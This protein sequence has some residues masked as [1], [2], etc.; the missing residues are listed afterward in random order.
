MNGDKM[1]GQNTCLSAEN[2]WEDGSSGLHAVLDDRGLVRVAG[3]QAGDF[4]QG[5]VS[6]DVRA[7]NPGNACYAAL[8]TPQGKVSCDFL[9][10]AQ[11]FEEFQLDCPKLLAAELVRRLTFYRLR[12]KVEIT[13][14]SHEVAIVA[15]WGDCGQRP[16]ASASFYRDPRDARLGWRAVLASDAGAAHRAHAAT[17]AYEDHRI[18]LRIPKGG[19]DFIYSDAFPHDANIDLLHGI[20]FNKGCYIGQE[21]IA[22]M[23]HRGGGRKRVARVF[24]EPPVPPV[25]AAIRTEDFLVGV[26]GSS[27]A[28]QGLATVRVDK[29]SAAVDRGQKIRA[30]DCALRVE[31]DF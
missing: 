14:R 25:G 9:I 4:L 1:P 24:F 8:L 30:N 16:K 11:S 26:M 7:L 20:D 2:L 31:L 17:D 23:H 5:L 15:L 13:D 28:G 21:V 27:T 22:R 12:A 10:F 29:V 3:P 18:R 6:N 19:M